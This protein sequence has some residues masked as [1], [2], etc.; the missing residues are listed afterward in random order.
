MIDEEKKAKV[1]E[2]W[3]LRYLSDRGV[4]A[5][6]L[7]GPEAF[8]ALCGLHTLRWMGTGSQ[9]EYERSED[10]PVCSRCWT[11]FYGRENV[12]RRSVD[13]AMYDTARNSAH[14]R[15]RRKYHIEF[16]RIYAEELQRLQ[17]EIATEVAKNGSRERSA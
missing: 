13:K 5:H 11:K 8:G 1:L 16:N 17:N 9:A 6:I 10:L 7:F 3:R 12:P 2:P 4:R 15:L 14:R